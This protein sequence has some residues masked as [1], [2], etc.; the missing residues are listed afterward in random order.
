M[1]SEK[2]SRGACLFVKQVWQQ[3][4]QPCTQKYSAPGFLILSAL[5]L[6]SCGRV[7]FIDMISNILTEGI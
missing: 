7:A 5:K 1:I 3:K 6:P 2:L 4:F